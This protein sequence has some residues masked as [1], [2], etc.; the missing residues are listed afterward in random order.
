MKCNFKFLILGLVVLFCS[1]SLVSCE[2]SKDNLSYV[3]YASKRNTQDMPSN[4][5]KNPLTGLDS[6]TFLALT[7]A[8]YDLIKAKLQ[9]YGTVNKVRFLEETKSGIQFHEV[10]RDP[11]ITFEVKEIYA[12]DGKVL[13]FIRA[14]LSVE[15]YVVVEKTEEKS[16]SYI[17]TK[18]C[19]MQGD[20]YGKN[21]DELVMQSLEFLLELF[22]KDYLAVNSTKPI[23]DLVDPSAKDE[24]GH[25]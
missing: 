14:S 17:W 23:F 18:N 6:F 2:K 10:S 25:E 13:P 24:Q 3:E 7:P 4:G 8:P 22:M 5:I 12:V 16:N 20:A 15:S 1:F 21:G 11:M 19:F 9:Q